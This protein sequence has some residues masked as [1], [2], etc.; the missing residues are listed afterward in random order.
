MSIPSLWQSLQ[1]T[2]IDCLTHFVAVYSSYS[3]LQ[4]I[5][6]HHLFNQSTVP[7]QWIESIDNPHLTTVF[8]CSRSEEM[9]AL[10]VLQPI[11]SVGRI[12][13]YRTVQMPEVRRCRVR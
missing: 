9:L 5:Y 8:I 1:S 6:L 10:R 11:P 3:T 4:S 7:S 12:S 2:K 13:D